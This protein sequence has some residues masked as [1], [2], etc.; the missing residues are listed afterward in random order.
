MVELFEFIDC[1]TISISY[2]TTGLATVSFTVVST[3][4]VPGLS[5]VRD[6]TD[7]TFGGINFKGF[8]TSLTTQIIP[9][10]IPPVFEHRFTETM[11][12][13]ANDCP[14]GATRP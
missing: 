7:L 8:V 14:R 2:Q 12:G 11:T 13:C 1:P 9:G 4:D 10:S 5:P 6:Y 3:Q